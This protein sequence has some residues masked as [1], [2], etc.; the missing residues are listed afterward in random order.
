M[1]IQ[2]LKLESKQSQA[3]LTQMPQTAALQKISSNFSV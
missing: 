3:T 2:N 1:E